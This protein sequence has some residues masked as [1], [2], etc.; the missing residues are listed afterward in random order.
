MIIIINH[1]EELKLTTLL[2]FY[3]KLIVIKLW[4]EHV[5]YCQSLL[6]TEFIHNV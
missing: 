3:L 5:T 6:N 2:L 4:Q 1:I